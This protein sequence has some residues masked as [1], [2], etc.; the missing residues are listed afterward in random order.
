M[1]TSEMYLAAALLAYGAELE[2]V[3]KSDPNHKK[4]CF[5]G[6]I[7][8]IFVL[9]SANVVLRIVDPSFD[10]IKTKFVAQTLLFPPTYVDS[11]RRIKA[12]I[13]D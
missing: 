8:Q 3:E 7:K 9:D 10:D 2:N 5:G 13:Y 11:I 12:V 6:D 4:F 1:K